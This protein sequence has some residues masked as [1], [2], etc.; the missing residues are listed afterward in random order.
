MEEVKN[1]SPQ[2]TE[3]DQVINSNSDVE[4]KND[5]VEYRYQN[6]MWKQYKKEIPYVATC[7]S[8]IIAV[9]S[10]AMSLIANGK[11]IIY[12]GY[13]NIDPSFAAAKSE[14]GIYCIVSTLVFFFTTSF[15]VRYVNKL[16]SSSKPEFAL[17]Y[18]YQF[19]NHHEEIKLRKLKKRYKEAKLLQ[20]KDGK[21]LERIKRKIKKHNITDEEVL[22]QFQALEMSHKSWND[23][24]ANTELEIQEHF[25]ENQSIK[26]DM[27]S[28]YYRMLISLFGRAMLASILYLFSTAL[29]NIYS[30]SLG[31]TTLFTWMGIN[32]VDLVYILHKSSE[33]K[34]DEYEQ[35]GK[36]NNVSSETVM[37]LYHDRCEKNKCLSQKKYS[38][39]SN[40]SIINISNLIFV[41][42]IT[43]ALIEFSNSWVS[44]KLQKEHW[45]YRDAQGVYTVLY[46]SEREYILEQIS[47]REN[48][49]IVDTA[50]QRILFSDDIEFERVEFNDVIRLPMK[51][52]SS[53][54]DALESEV[55]YAV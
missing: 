15:V 53:Q 4:E 6:T 48:N 11:D 44:A 10:F 52:S 1:I 55:R 23:R 22:K 29:M 43:V 40:E 25:Q 12:L 7:V 2:E 54:I 51:N 20:R 21:E 18:G 36:L 14:N 45:I 28:V 26:R 37:Q 19:M 46:Q 8:A 5:Q 34:K 50:K 13:W 3:G 38:M 47:I 31:I 39:F 27:K 32:I 9:I 41:S 33:L 17:I 49:I 24:N 42:L 35:L 16:L 30:G